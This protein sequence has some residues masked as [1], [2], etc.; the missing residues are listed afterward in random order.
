MGGQLVYG[1]ITELPAVFLLYDSSFWS[2]V[3]LLVIFAVSVWNGG[4]YY[5]E[6]FGRKFERELEALRKELA[7]SNARSASGRS[8][9][10]A[11]DLELSSSP[12]ASP[13]QA[14]APMPSLDAGVVLT[15]CAGAARTRSEASES[16]TSLKKAE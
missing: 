6:V 14:P 16:E 2:G 4:G 3:F 12:G 11:S 8:S 10:A 7:E 13:K 15:G 5:I 9:P 1:V